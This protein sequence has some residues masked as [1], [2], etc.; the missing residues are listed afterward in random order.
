MINFD[1][2][3]C[4]QNLDARKDMAGILVVCP[5]CDGLLSIPESGENATEVEA[6]AA[7][8]TEK[9]STVRINLPPG[10]K[11]PKHPFKIIKIKRPV[12]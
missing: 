7:T 8:E 6:P 1:C 3:Y 9:G 12:A 11:L 10:L 5:S 4:R 2:P